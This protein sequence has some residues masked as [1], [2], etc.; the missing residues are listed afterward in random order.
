[1]LVKSLY[2]VGLSYVFYIYNAFV[3]KAILRLFKQISAE[4]KEVE[5][6]FLNYK[7][8]CIF[9]TNFL[10]YTKRNKKKIM[11]SRRQ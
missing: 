11:L 10:E 5:F 4:Q 9:V 8:H 6:L 2:F 3:F 1:M 7:E